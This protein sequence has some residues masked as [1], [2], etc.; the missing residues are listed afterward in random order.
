MCKWLV[1][2]DGCDFVLI[3]LESQTHFV[4]ARIVKRCKQVSLHKIS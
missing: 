1:N 2:K 3:M 4:C